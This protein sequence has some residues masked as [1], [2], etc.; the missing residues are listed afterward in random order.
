MLGY[1]DTDDNDTLIGVAHERTMQSAE[2]LGLKVTQ[3][4]RDDLWDYLRSL[5]TDELKAIKA[6]PD[7]PCS[8]CGGPHP[9]SAHGYWVSKWGDHQLGIAESSEEK[10]AAAAAVVFMDFEP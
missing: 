4:N 1:D 5:Q 3:E 6:K 7:G 8:Q 10:P 9:D 2:K